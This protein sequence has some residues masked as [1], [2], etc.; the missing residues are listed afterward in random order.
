MTGYHSTVSIE[1]TLGTKCSAKHLIGLKT[2]FSI[3]MYLKLN[4]AML[5]HLGVYLNLCFASIKT[6]LT[7][8]NQFDRNGISKKQFLF[9]H[10][11]QQL[12]LH[13][14]LQFFLTSQVWI[15]EAKTSFGLISPEKP[16]MDN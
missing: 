5:A 15:K 3:F 8:A 13:F 9:C 10:F 4:K 11:F 7:L 12:F 16:K 1:I 14:W 6:L 2:L